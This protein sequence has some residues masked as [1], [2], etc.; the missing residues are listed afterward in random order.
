MKMVRL[1]MN[2]DFRNG[3]QRVAEELKKA[4]IDMSSPVSPR[5]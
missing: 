3:V 1:A 4:G 2:P 5:S